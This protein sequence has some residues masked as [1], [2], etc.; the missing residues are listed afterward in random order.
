MNLPTN[1]MALFLASSSSS[2]PAMKGTDT[3]IR[4]HFLPMSLNATAAT[5]GTQAAPIM[6]MLTTQASAEPRSPRSAGIWVSCRELAVQAITL[7]R[8]NAPNV[9]EKYKWN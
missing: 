7:P 8:A 4:V 2:H 3:A 6:N 1:N 5:Q 9:A